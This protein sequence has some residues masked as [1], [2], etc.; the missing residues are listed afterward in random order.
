M[1][2][3]RGQELYRPATEQP[4]GTLWRTLRS[5]HCG[6]DRHNCSTGPQRKLF[7]TDFSDP[8][9]SARL[10][11]VDLAGILARKDTDPSRSARLHRVDLAGILARKDT[12]PSRPAR[13]HRVDLVGILKMMNT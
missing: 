2:Q 12:D 11:R 8:S 13:L 3:L 10:H 5:A 1:L 6:P 9:R 7:S 4:Y